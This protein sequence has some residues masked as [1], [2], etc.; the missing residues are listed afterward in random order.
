M[1]LIDTDVLIQF[2]KGDSRAVKALEAMSDS[3]AVSAITAMEL[4]F[5]GR[6]KKE[7]KLLQKFLS[8][9]I[10]LQLDE[11]ISRKGIAMIERYAKSHGLCIPDALIAATALLKNLELL[12]CNRKDFRFIDGILL[13]DC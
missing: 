10:I 9:F 5:G 6:D 8:N 2:L 7:I 3:R 11:E 13:Y 12:T 1:I 4:Y